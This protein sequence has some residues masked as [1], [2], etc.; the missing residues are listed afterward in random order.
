MGEVSLNNGNAKYERIPFGSEMLKQFL[1]DPAYKNLNHGSFGAFPRVIRDAQRVFQDECESSPD[2]FIFYKY[3]KFLDESRAAAAKLLDVPV[4][5]VVFVSNATL[6]VNTVLRNIQWHEDG[7][8]EVIYFSTIYGACGKTVTYLCESTRNLVQARTVTLNYPLSDASVLE[9]FKKAITASRADRKVPRLAIFD[10][11]SSVPGI[12]MPFEGLV[13]ICAEEGIL[14]LVDAAHGIGQIPLSLS[15][16]QPD[17]F[18]TNLH[19]WLFVPRGCALLYVPFKNQALMRSSLPTSHS[20]TPLVKGPRSL[21]GFPPNTK[22]GFVNNFEFVGTIDNSNYL[23]AAEA[24]K[25]RQ[26]ACGGEEAIHD[27]CTKLVKEGG[28][29]VADILGTKILDYEEHGLTDC[30]MINVLLPLALTPTSAAVPDA[31]KPAAH[32]HTVKE[33]HSFLVRH[34]AHRTLVDDYK[35]YIFL[36]FSRG[37]WWAR[38]SAQVY[39]EMSDFEWAGRTLKEICERVGKEEFLVSSLDKEVEALEKGVE[40]VGLAEA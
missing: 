36:Y 32:F 10:T 2:E 22:T 6:G 12:R 27:Y 18:V 21:N 15:T 25:W 28:K 5:T 37:Q 24:I 13:K 29:L 19:K 16:L 31:D 38:L 1:F 20:F 33:E 26:E 17:F 40:G 3:P 34:W 39:L 11:I 23:V 9:G 4:D 35:T 7:R 8:D 30:F 14:S